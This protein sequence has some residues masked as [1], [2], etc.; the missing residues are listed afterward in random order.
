MT[1]ISGFTLSPNE[2]IIIQNL[3]KNISIQA[4]NG[5]DG[6]LKLCATDDDLDP[7]VEGSEIRA[8]VPPPWVE[9]PVDEVRRLPFF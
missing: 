3:F 7:P 9:S 8:G 6:I 4:T 1:V 2:N 5:G